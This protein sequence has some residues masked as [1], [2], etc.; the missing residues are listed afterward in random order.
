MIT[1]EELGS[2]LLLWICIVSNVMDVIVFVT[3][4]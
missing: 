3:S 2:L 1:V 4:T